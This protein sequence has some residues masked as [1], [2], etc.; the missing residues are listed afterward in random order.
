MRS[1][2]SSVA[3]A[4]KARLRPKT[5]LGYFVCFAFAAA[6]LILVWQARTIS[7]LRSETAALRQELLLSIDGAMEKTGVHPTPQATAW[8]DK[9]ELIK[10]RHQVRDLKETMVESHATDS[11][12]GFK[13][14]I[15]AL[16]PKPDVSAPFT[17][18]SEWARMEAHATNRYAAAM[19]HLAGSTNEYLRFLS[20]SEAAR[21][22]LVVG[23]TADARTFAN[24]LLVLDEKFSRGI[25]E[26]AD[27]DA[28]HTAHVVLGT[29]ALDAGK[30]DEAKRHLLAAG[31]T[32]GSPVLNSFGP[33][34]SLACDLLKKGEQETVLQYLDLCRKFWKVTELDKWE[35]D[36]EAGRIPDFGAGLIH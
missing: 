25:P 3:A 19:R 1:G 5:P 18:R 35:K 13:A 16:I 7:E 33:N 14:A 12:S 24:D 22:S 30:I 36:I 11:K 28:V 32:R 2:T 31:K 4:D 34:M 29:L 10:L 6:L 9:L 26:K 21:M 23:H 17:V 8:R 20:L 27:G 15:N